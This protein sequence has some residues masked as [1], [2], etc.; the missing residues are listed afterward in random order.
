MYLHRIHLNLRCKEARRDVSDP[1]EMHSTLC[2]AFSA[3]DAKCSQGA[4]LWRLEPERRSDGMPKIVI[5]SRE[6]PD[7]SRINLPEWFWAKPALPIDI[8]KKLALKDLE[9][10]KRFRYRLRANP[11]ASHKGKRFGLF[12]S[13][14]QVSWFQR[15]GEK[16]GFKSITIHRSEERM[17]TGNIRSGHPIRV[18]SVLFDGILEIIDPTLFGKAVSD[19][20]GHG[21]A[22]GLGLLSVI[23]VE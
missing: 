9:N 17:L 7:W 5:Q 13:T 8:M 22:M 20:I 21:K 4:F 23:P 10:G 14:A 19:G 1:Y 11:V 16:N 15:Q 18:F 3:P 6:L 12:E 2:R